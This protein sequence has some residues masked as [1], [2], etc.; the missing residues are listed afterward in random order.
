M[1]G[2]RVPYAR[3]VNKIMGELGNMNVVHAINLIFT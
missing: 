2:T 3:N 1:R